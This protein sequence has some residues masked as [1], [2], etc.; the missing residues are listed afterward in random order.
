MNLRLIEQRQLTVNNKSELSFDE[1][2]SRR[3]RITITRTLLQN[4]PY[5]IMNLFSDCIIVAIKYDFTVDYIEYTCYCPSFEK[6]AEGTIAP[7]YSV[8]I[9]EGKPCKSLS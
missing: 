7:I 4:H 1:L 6:C 2:S 9:K 3:G 5:F 8:S